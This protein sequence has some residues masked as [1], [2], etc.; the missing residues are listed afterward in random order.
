MCWRLPALLGVGGPTERRPQDVPAPGRAPVR[1][2][3]FL[4]PGAEDGDTGLLP[5][6]GEEEVLAPEAKSRLAPLRETSWSGGSLCG[7]RALAFLKAVQN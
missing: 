7:R 1:R 6:P 4:V 3:V 2:E 5:P